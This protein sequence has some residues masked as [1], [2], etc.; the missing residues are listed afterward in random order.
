[1]AASE[2]RLS[3]IQHKQETTTN[4]SDSPKL[5]NLH[6]NLH[7]LSSSS[8]VLK[9]SDTDGFTERSGMGNKRIHAPNEK[10]FSHMIDATKNEHTSLESSPS[11]RVER[12]N[13]RF[14]QDYGKFMEKL[15]EVAE[16]LDKVMEPFN[17]VKEKT[18]RYVRPVDNMLRAGVN[19]VD[20]ALES[21]VMKVLN[22]P[23]DNKNDAHDPNSPDKARDPKSRSDVLD[24]EHTYDPKSP[25]PLHEQ[26]TL[27][28]ASEEYG[29]L[30]KAYEQMPSEKTSSK[31]HQK[32]KANVAEKGAHMLEHIIERK[33]EKTLHKLSHNLK[34]EASHLERDAEVRHIKAEAADKVWKTLPENVRARADAGA[35]AAEMPP[36][37]VMIELNKTAVPDAER[38]GAQ[39][40]RGLSDLAKNAEHELREKR[41]TSN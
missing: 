25:D 6:R 10:E 22:S 38:G 18:D 40:L 1:M 14:S 34:R 33:G 8:D 26:S 32:A 7:N 20:G 23:L 17:K 36:P 9:P 35:I 13:A 41:K 3:E 39:H 11:K 12:G 24:K 31:R 4:H 21:I 2:I 29:P 30:K 28:N 15:G 27:E 5:N 16:K 37:G 19:H